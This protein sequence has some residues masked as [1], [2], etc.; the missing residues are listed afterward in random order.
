[1]SNSSSDGTGAVRVVKDPQGGFD[2]LGQHA[3]LSATSPGT[4][5]EPPLNFDV[6]VVDHSAG[7]TDPK[8]AALAVSGDVVLRGNR[9]TLSGDDVTATGTYVLAGG[10][11]VTLSNLHSVTFDGAPGDDSLTVN[12]NPNNPLLPTPLAYHGS[13][14][15]ANGLMINGSS[16]DPPTMLTPAPS[17]GVGQGTAPPGG[18]AQ[19]TGPQS[20]GY[21]NV[22]TL[23]LSA[24]ASVH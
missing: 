22:A 13:G 7:T 6:K 24:P 8:G 19:I 23:R 16:A 11:A 18:P 21:V 15:G 14:D 3:Y 9:L 5:D 17:G 12:L 10:P 1:T 20:A 2:V 4:V